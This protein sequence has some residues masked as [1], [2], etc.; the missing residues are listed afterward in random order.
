MQKGDMLARILGIVVFV[1]G[2]AVL[3]VTFIQAYRL[4]TTPE[5]LLIPAPTD[6]NEDAAAPGLGINALV[7]LRQIGLLFIMA[8]VGSLVASRGIQLYF[9]GTPGDA[10][11][12]A[13]SE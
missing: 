9:R 2:I 12:K 6:A 5:A 1:V 11:P 7:L 3:V 8:L 4:F 13:Q 10:E